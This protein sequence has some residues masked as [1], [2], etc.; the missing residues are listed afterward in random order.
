MPK[1]ITDRD[2]TELESKIK[3]AKLGSVEWFIDTYNSGLINTKNWL[4]SE[5]AD[6][7]VSTY[8][9]VEI[10]RKQFVFISEAEIALN[11]IMYNL[12]SKWSYITRLKREVDTYKD[13][14]TDGKVYLTLEGHPNDRGMVCARVMP[15]T[16]F[17]TEDEDA[18]DEM[19]L[20]ALGVEKV[21]NN[22]QKD[23]FLNALRS[24]VAD[25]SQIGVF[26]EYVEI[27]VFVVN[28]IN[29]SFLEDMR[30]L[31]S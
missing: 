3:K 6:E 24:V 10:K 28:S 30:E 13:Q 15:E 17:H 2:T 25:K 4:I 20:E 11:E 21:F 9:N 18:H 29:D 27:P 7:V 8:K 26:D 5:I 31:M 23:E 16:E 22:D 1:L 12:G 14:F 19:R